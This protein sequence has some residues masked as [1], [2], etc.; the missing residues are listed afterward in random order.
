[1]HVSSTESGWVRHKPADGAAVWA[2]GTAQ[3]QR[4]TMGAMSGLCSHQGMGRS[5]LC[6]L[7]TGLYVDDAS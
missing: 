2:C 7:V 5:E 4:R 3:E 1:M 6:A